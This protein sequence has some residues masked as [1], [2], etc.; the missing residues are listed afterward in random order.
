MFLNTSI[1][2]IVS[3]KITFLLGIVP[4]SFTQ[5][6]LSPG[7]AASRTGGICGEAY[8]TVPQPPSRDGADLEQD[9]FYQVFVQRVVYFPD[10]LFLEKVKVVQP[11]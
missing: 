5:V 1:P 3:L 10:D 7:M 6:F 4:L 9:V 11:G 8:F 2:G